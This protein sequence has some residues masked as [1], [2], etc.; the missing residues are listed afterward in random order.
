MSQGR[1]AAA[2]R[3]KQEAGTKRERPIE[4]DAEDDEVTFVGSRNKKRRR[5]LDKGVIVLD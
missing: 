3:F 1:D 2:R 5:G 4:V